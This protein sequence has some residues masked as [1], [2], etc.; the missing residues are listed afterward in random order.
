ME[1]LLVQPACRICRA[2]CSVHHCKRLFTTA[3]IR[4]RWASRLSD[5]LLVPATRGDGLP[6]Q[7]CHRCSIKI[8]SIEE[9]LRNL[10]EMRQSAKSMIECFCVP[11]LKPIRWNGRRIQVVWMFHL[12]QRDHCQPQS[13]ALAYSLDNCSSTQVKFPVREKI[14]LHACMIILYWT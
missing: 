3:G 4:E 10:E 5:L 8:K 9:S 6:A 14:V 2:C 13:A 12:K 7:I 1:K 11:T